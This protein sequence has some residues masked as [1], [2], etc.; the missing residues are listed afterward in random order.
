MFVTLCRL[1]G[2]ASTDAVVSFSAQNLPA[3]CTPSTHLK[4]LPMHGTTV[5]SRMLLID[6]S[7]GSFSIWFPFPFAFSFL[8]LIGFLLQDKKSLGI[9]TWETVCST[10]SLL[11][12]TLPD[13]LFVMCHVQLP[14]NLGVQK[15]AS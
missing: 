3:L 4:Q 9:F 1:P 11:T 15:L 14:Q 6:H 2:P 7:G 12:E 10:C 13:A 5:L 8:L